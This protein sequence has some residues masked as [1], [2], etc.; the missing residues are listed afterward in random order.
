MAIVNKIRE[1]SGIAVAVIAVAL[2]L[3]IVGGDIFSNQGGGLFGSSNNEVGE[4][5]GTTVDYQQYVALV[6][7]QKLQLESST[8]R[9]ATEQETAQ[10]R[11]QVWE[12][13]IFENV[14][15]DEFEK[16]GITVSD[17]ELRELI[18]GAKNMHPY[19]KQQFSDQQGNFNAAQHAEF[20]RSY[21]SG[22][23][24]AAQKA[25]WDNFKRELKTIRMREKYSNLLNKASFVTT[26][27]A[28]AEYVANTEKAS[29]KFLFVPFY[30]IQDSTVKVEDSE[31]KDYFSKHKEEFAPFDSRS[32]TYVAYQLTPTKDDSAALNTEI[33]NLAKGLAAAPNAQTYASANTDIR[34]PYLRSANE[35]SVELKAAL[36]TAIVGSLVGPFK[37]GNT[38]SIHK[39]EGTDTD[40]LYT[41]RASH[42]LIRSDST[43][44]DSAK[45]A[46]RN[47]AQDILNQAKSGADFAMLASQ[48]GTDG[49]A[50][51]GGDLGTFQNNGA[52]VKP[53][54][55]AIF[56]F[57]GT[58]II[59]NLVTTDFGYHI[60]KVT[61]PK[62]NTKYKLASI[63][64][65]LQVGEL[66][67]NE[68]FQKAENLRASVKTLKDLE[69]AVK[70][71]NSLTLLNAENLMP[72][73]TNVNTIQNARE[74]V[75]WAYGKDVEEGD[76]AD[77]VFVLGETY[78]VAALKSAADK[79]NP[80]AMDFKDAI[81]VKVRNEKKTEKI[82][83]KLGDGKGD[84]I[85]LSK[86]YGAG[87]LVETVT[88]VNFFSGMLNSA[89]FDPI[90]LGKLFG[91]KA[92][93][94]SKVFAGESGVFVMETTAKTAAPVIT[95]YTAYKQQ[96]EQRTGMGRMG[97]IGEQI[98]RENAKI[99]D[100]RAKLF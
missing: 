60:V 54:E 81:T 63:N 33:R 4:I 39:F 70:K 76:V 73:S 59:P 65:E 22:S 11:E 98:L 53:F 68:M 34:T 67:S 26:A 43:M 100:N 6:E 13:L 77:R 38:Y 27:E 21:T 45:T 49:T 87:A 72:N 1:R 88:D 56:G 92:G 41:V 48:N 30:S 86:K 16:L 29:G 90:A 84:L 5:N 69:A 50:Q 96:V 93:Q 12:K 66:A 95:D 3:F 18:Q 83:A 71:D 61:E 8:G 79:E 14:Y 64:K 58:G 15:V 75:N 99:V 74:I 62:S 55:S 47:K 80:E 25:M 42:I 9:S 37:E 24:P 89:G 28:K 31:I 7:A 91:L 51:N 94:R 44:S 78:V 97:M 10:I 32:I 23:M 36:S 35:L 85:A 82:V 46:A 20:I 17:D 2:L 19:V 40:S 52:M 57:S